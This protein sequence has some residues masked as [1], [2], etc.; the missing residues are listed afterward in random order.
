MRFNEPLIPEKQW[1]QIFEESGG[2]ISY[3]QIPVPEPKPDEVLVDVKYT[4]VCHTDLH[5]WKG[6]WQEN[7][8]TVKPLVGGHEGAGVVV[9]L[10]S[11]VDKKNFKVGQKVGIP[12]IN[13][14]CGT[15]PYCE[16]FWRIQKTIQA[17]IFRFGWPS[18]TLPNTY[19]L[20]IYAKWHFPTVCPSPSQP[21]H[22]NT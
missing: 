16:Y 21:G 3:K 8:E 19:D 15:C 14:T 4:G 5:A 10:G 13:G 7:L 6:D 20:W 11:L 9:K 22:Q 17:D 1:A 2:E 18:T 12:W